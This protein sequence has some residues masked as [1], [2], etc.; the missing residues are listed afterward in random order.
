MATSKTVFVIIEC[1]HPYVNEF[2]AFEKIVS[3]LEIE[4]NTLIRTIIAEDDPQNT[5]SAFKDKI[6]EPIKSADA[7]VCFLPINQEESRFDTRFNISFELG[8][9]IAVAEPKTIT[10]VDG[11]KNTPFDMNNADIVFFGTSYETRLR[12]KLLKTLNLGTSAKKI[13]TEAEFVEGLKPIEGLLKSPPLDSNS[14]MRIEELNTKMRPMVLELTDVTIQKIREILQILMNNDF[15]QSRSRFLP[16]LIF[17]QENNPEFVRVVFDGDIVNQLKFYAD[18]YKG[19]NYNIPA[20]RLLLEYDMNDG[21]EWLF[22]YG[23]PSLGGS[24]DLLKKTVGG[25]F[26]INTPLNQKLIT[27][28]E[29]RMGNVV[30]YE[31]GERKIR[32][33]ESLSLMHR[34]LMGKG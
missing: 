25:L 33:M 18:F 31:D 17:Q 14:A 9:A 19:F 6:L 13:M 4:T 23:N 5:F 7:V 16:L 27:D 8:L 32:L 20:L 1:K 3:E 28:I 21:L 29:R 26:P 15:H 2:A 34:S 24:S 30:N 11:K 12:K 10:I 22:K